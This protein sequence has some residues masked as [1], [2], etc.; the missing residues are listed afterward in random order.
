MIEDS[1]QMTHIMIEYS[2]RRRLISGV[3][4]MIAIWLMGP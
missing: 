1:F 2:P 3:L 4:L